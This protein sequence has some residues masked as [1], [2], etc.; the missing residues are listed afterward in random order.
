TRALGWDTKSPEGYSSAGQF[1]G[2]LSFGH[3]GFTGTSIW[4]DPEVG[5]FVI[6]LS[7]RVYPTRNNRRLTPVRPALAD[8]VFETMTDPDHQRVVD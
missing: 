5:L 2:P 3:T 7:N 4:F 6:L 1:F 8:L